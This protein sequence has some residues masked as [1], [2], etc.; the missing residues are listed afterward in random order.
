MSQGGDKELFLFYF[1]WIKGRIK[2]LV[3]EMML[4]GLQQGVRDR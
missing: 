4:S 1:P 2:L 3:R